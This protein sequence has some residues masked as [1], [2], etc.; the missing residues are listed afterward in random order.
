MNYNF[1]AQIGVIGD[2]KIRS[3]N[4]FEI[5]FEL[6]QE[7]ALANAVL[8]CGGRGGVMEAVSKGVYDSGGFSI[9]ILPTD[10]KDPEVLVV[11]PLW[12]GHE[13]S[14]ETK[15]TI[16][17]NDIKYLWIASEGPNNIPT[18]A[19]L[20]LKW[21]KQNRSSLPPYYIMIDRD[22]TL[23]RHM[24]DR[25]A[26]NLAKA[27]VIQPEIAYTYAN[28]EFKGHFNREFPAMPFNPNQLM[29]HNYISSNS[30]FLSEVIDEIGLVTDDHFKRLL[31]WCFLLKLFYHDRI[32]IPCT[33]ASFVACSTKND[34]SAG[35]PQDYQ[36]KSMRVN[37]YFI[38]PI[39]EDKQKM[40]IPPSK[41]EVIDI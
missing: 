3:K 9:G 15:I 24:L 20:G 36:I 16:K 7:I 41:L 5:C 6:G 8:I 26:K 11:T 27:H 10:E 37:E 35:S 30:M 31:D 1:T 32:G 38:R 34:I 13:I 22:I 17:R 28:F 29:Q 19:K 12:P 18:N 40:G 2:S 33:Q 4:Q 14:K 39:L 23:G 21:T 25:M